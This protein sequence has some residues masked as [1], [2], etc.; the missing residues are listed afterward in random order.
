MVQSIKPILQLFQAVYLAEAPEGRY[1]RFVTC[2]TDEEAAQLVAS[3]LCACDVLKSG[4]QVMITVFPVPNIGNVKQVHFGLG[5]RSFEIVVPKY[6]RKR[7]L[8]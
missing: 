1:S 2:A 3:D 6:I 7:G 4:M 5:A 8:R